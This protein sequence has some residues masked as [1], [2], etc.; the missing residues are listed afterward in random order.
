MNSPETNEQ[1]KKQ[2]IAS[3]HGIGAILGFIGKSIA[4][5]CIFNHHVF[6]AEIKAIDYYEHP[7]DAGEREI[8][9]RIS[10]PD[11]RSVRIKSGE[12]YSCVVDFMP[13]VKL[14]SDH[15]IGMDAVYTILEI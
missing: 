7:E 13:H 11:V 14:P 2:L 8:F 12:K 9:L 1:F 15:S 6:V 3:V 10:H 5:E 4:I